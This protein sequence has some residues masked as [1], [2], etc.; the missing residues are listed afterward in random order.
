[1]KNLY[2]FLICLV[3]VF[4][5]QVYAQ[6]CD[7]TEY[8]YLNEPNNSGNPGIHKFELNENYNPADPASTVVAQEIGSPWFNN[9]AAG[10]TVTNP[11][12]MAIDLNGN[13][14]VGEDNTVGDGVIRK[15]RCDGTILPTTDFSVNDQGYSI[16][17][18]GNTIYV[19]T[20]DFDDNSPNYINAYDVCTGDL[21]GFYCLS[22]IEASRSDW[23]LYL[24]NGILYATNDFRP[25]GSADDVPDNLFVFD[26]NTTPLSAPGDANPTCISPFISQGA[27][28]PVIGSNAFAR[29]QIFGVVTDSDGF[30]Y[31][32]E[33]TRTGE[34]DFP[35]G[36]ADGSS[37]ILKYD[38][39]GNLVAVTPY[40]S[41][42][43]DGGYFQAI[44]IYYSQ[45]LDLIFV[46][47]ASP[48]DDCVSLFDTDLNY[49][50]AA[51]PSPGDGTQ[52]K[53][54]FITQ[55]CC[56]TTTPVL[57]D[58]TLCN[59]TLGEQIFLLDL[60]GCTLCEGTWAVD[61]A[62]NDFNFDA[63]SNSIVI[64][65]PNECGSFT[66][67]SDGTAAL[68]QCAAFE[69][70]INVCTTTTAPPAISITNNVCD[71][72]TAGSINVDT[73]CPA[74]NTI[75]YSIDSGTNWSATA[76]AYD[77]ANAI[78]VRARCV[79]DAFNTCIS[80]ETV[81]VTS[82]PEVCTTP[83]PPVNCINQFGE[84][85]IQKSIP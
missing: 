48:T 37:R 14:Y 27:T 32:V 9:A 12:G 58:I 40:D 51:V 23:G 54:I 82:T 77:T 49:L 63:C 44:G 26:V 69:V 6:N 67:S 75:E 8:L 85:T 80:T 25:E 29:D 10:E 1:M 22:G 83:C 4:T 61:P 52:G 59:P 57:E 53:A 84:F 38:S 62:Q 70:T 11:H 21:L 60:V 5:N 56:P 76:P 68:A 47:T 3:V 33:R 35:G 2:L 50:G 74:G 81:D 41:D 36:I 16:V 45:T 39:S 71:P 73:P 24:D 17:S 72:E 78:T 19:G 31:I 20:Q 18:Q 13:I 55:E 34:P 15:F 46:S 7:C 65:T 42:D 64:D 66:L 28:G 79:N 43:T 30:I